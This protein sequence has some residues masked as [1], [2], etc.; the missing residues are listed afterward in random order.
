MEDP[1]MSE[2]SEAIMDA[3]EKRIRRA[4]YNGFSFREIATDMG[5]ASSSIH[6]HFSTKD[7]L[8]AAVARRYSDRFEQVV[9]AEVAAGSSLTN[10][11]HRGFRRALAEDGRM[12]LC[13]A[14]GASAQDLPEEVLVEAQ[15]FFKQG[16]TTLEQSGLSGEEAMRLL[17]TLEGAMLMANTLRDVSAF[18]QATSALG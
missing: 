4:G 18:D 11:W 7:A 5:M 14:L 12:C 6:H 17:A 8:A 1:A 9:T 10:A 2:K 3:A 16:L 15:R 13:G